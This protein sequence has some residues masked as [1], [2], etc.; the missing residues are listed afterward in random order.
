MLNKFKNIFKVIL[1]SLLFLIFLVFIFSNT[2]IVKINL[3]PFSTIIEIRM[4]LLII[5]TFIFGFLFSMFLNLLNDA[6]GLQKLKYN[7]KI[8]NMEK[9]IQILKNK[10]IEEYD[11]DNKKN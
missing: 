3:F 5:I 2:G 8:T 11:K 9:E 7:L 6:F 10:S 4:F 1:I